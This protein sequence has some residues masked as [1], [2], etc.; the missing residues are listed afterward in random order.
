MP[1]LS[2]EPSTLI[3][4]ALQ[5]ERARDDVTI[6]DDYI[7]RYAANGIGGEFF[8]IA[9]EGHQHAVQQVTATMNR[10]I[11]V[12]DYSATQLRAAARN[13]QQ[14]DMDAASS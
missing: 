14:A 1:A 10:L 5:I 2:V 13:Y 4:Y 12:M 7:A 9:A 6:V 3:S 8:G 11:C